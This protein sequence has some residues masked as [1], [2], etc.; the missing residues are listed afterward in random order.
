MLY[1]RESTAGK[2][3]KIRRTTPFGG[4]STTS[5]V[6]RG[7]SK[8]YTTLSSYRPDMN[9]R[10]ETHVYSRDVYNLTNPGFTPTG[11]SPVYIDDP[12]PSETQIHAPVTQNR[13]WEADFEAKFAEPRSENGTG[14]R[15]R[16]RKMKNQRRPR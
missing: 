10:P 1:A 16:K 9:E 13:T 14:R 7:V 2:K 3:K 5:T 15:R 8:S 11:K 12:S 6:R 4:Q